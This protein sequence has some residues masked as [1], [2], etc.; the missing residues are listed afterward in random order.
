ME[1]I[2]GVYFLDKVRG[3]NVYLLVDKC[4]AIIDTGI[5]GNHTRIINFIRG[6]GRN[7]EELIHIILTH[8]H[9][10]HIGS[11]VELQRATGAKIVV[12][13]DELVSTPS[14]NYV[15]APHPEEMH[16]WAERIMNRHGMLKFSP[17][18]IAV[19]DGQI[20]PYLG[21]LSIIHTPGH[22][23]GS[24]CLLLEKSGVLFVGDT[25][26]NNKD[27]LSRPIPFHTDKNISEQSLLK[28]TGY[29]FTICC[30]GHGPILKQ[31][32][33]KKVNN[34]VRSYPDSSLW[35]RIVRNFCLLIKFFIRLW[36]K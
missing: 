1:I 26:I 23:R 12:H 19:E 33:Y 25:I 17:T 32:A 30:F 15:L 6:L 10:D 4:L 36:H 2:P 9:I 27:R 8:G 29:N 28:I 18:D 7:P 3:S 11:A 31:D 22:T 34:L 14:G 5:P 20:L 16:G 13:K 21:G 24:M 35:R